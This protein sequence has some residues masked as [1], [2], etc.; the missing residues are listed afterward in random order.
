[1]SADPFSILPSTSSTPSEFILDAGGAGRVDARLE[2]AGLLDVTMEEAGRAVADA[3]QA[4]FPTGTVLLLAGGGANGGDAFVAA[5]HLHCLGRDV[6]VLAQPPK[7]PLT[8]LNRRRWQAVG[9]MTSTLSVS[10]VRRWLPQVDLL[11]DGLLGTGFRP[12]LRSGLLEVVEV[13]RE[14]RAS[15]LPVLA[16][17]LPSGLDAS[18]ADAA[19]PSVVADHTVTLMG[20]KTALLYGQSAAQAGAVTLVPLR[21]P[22]EWVAREALG[23]RPSDA[24]I[25][26]LLPV[27]R[28]DA[29]KGTAGR[30]WV[31]G[32]HPGTTGAAALAGVGALRAGAG[33]VTL[34]SQAEV[35]LVV[36]EL[37]FRRVEDWKTM[38]AEMRKEP[39]N[40][41]AV[42]M[43]LGPQA[44]AVAREVLSWGI[45]AVVDADALQPE[46]AGAG[47]PQV[48]W[49]PHPGEAARLLGV[50]TGEVTQ[51]P[52]QAASTLQH[53]LGGVVILKGGPSTIAFPSGLSVSRG[54]HPGMAKAGMG[55]TLSGI[56][57]A[58]LGQGLSAHDAALAGVRLHARA[59]E[60]A[61]VRHGYG[62][63][64]SDLALELGAAWAD[65]KASSAG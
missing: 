10:G 22:P 3:V 18:Q 60:R 1:M 13:I 50:A 55:D 2:R 9:G 19:Q 36:P 4:H 57:A 51:H 61:A 46:L 8:R 39:P 26:R 64:A 42:G 62:L 54:G 30:V 17:D 16:I 24:A 27:R 23:T 34:Y 6:R 45:P 32:G 31:L 53:R 58:L 47:H 44:L 63:T 35:P 11:V 29:H 7:H 38:L 59:G 41:A 28:A 25:G 37:M 21:V 56:L 20:W 33:L 40:A 12:P 15:R 65:L 49:T 52:L 48:I 5:R 14:A 43:G